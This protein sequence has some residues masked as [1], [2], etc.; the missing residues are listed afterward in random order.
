M[1]W[2]RYFS[3]GNWDGASIS[4]EGIRQGQVFQK[5]ELGRGRYF[6]RRNWVGAGYFSRG[7]FSRTVE[8]NSVFG[9]SWLHLTLIKYFK[10]LEEVI[11][12]VAFMAKTASLS[13]H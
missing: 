9:A 6:S 12:S 5:R 4:V 1:G 3:R 11:T 2:G 7:K 8:W 13:G 10:H